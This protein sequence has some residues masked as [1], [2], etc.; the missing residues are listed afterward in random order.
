MRIVFTSDCHGKLEKGHL[1]PGD[2]LCMAG[3]ILPNFSRNPVVDAARQESALKKLDDMLS[4][5]SF[6]HVLLVAGNHDWIFEVAK[7]VAKSILKKITYVED[8]AVVIDG[9]KFYGSPWQPEFCG[10][11]F[12]LPRKG[13]QLKA[14]WDAIPNDTDVLITHGPPWG[15]LDQI[16]PTLEAW[17]PCGMRSVE[18][19]GCEL[20]AERIKIVKPKVHAFGHIH[21]SYGKQKVGDSLLLNAA[22]CNEGYRPTNTP[23]VVE[24]NK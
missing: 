6:K 21:G 7:P 20:L 3:D 9:V 2:V 12:N 15:H 17:D 24:L 14:R 19:L 22:L 18:H 8:E 5:T 13:D 11:A 4:E 16:K 23:H 10:W 1:P